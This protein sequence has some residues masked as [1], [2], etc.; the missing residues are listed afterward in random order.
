M[1]LIIS[2]RKLSWKAVFQKVKE[3]IFKV[4]KC[5]SPIKIDLESKGKIFK[6]DPKGQPKGK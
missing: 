6:R 2:G 1:A 5:F 3:S 4:I